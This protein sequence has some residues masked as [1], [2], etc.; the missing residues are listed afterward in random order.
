MWAPR[1]VVHLK[2]GEPCFDSATTREGRTRKTARKR[3]ERAVVKSRRLATSCTKGTVPTGEHGG[4][5]CRLVTA[6]GASFRPPVSA[7]SGRL[8]PKLALKVGETAHR[9]GLVQQGGGT[10]TCFYGQCSSMSR[11]QA[12]LRPDATGACPSPVGRDGIVVFLQQCR[13]FTIKTR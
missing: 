5:V 7:N 10:R 9:P 12:T 13:D 8:D 3:D 1:S 11:V 6:T 4:N 2:H